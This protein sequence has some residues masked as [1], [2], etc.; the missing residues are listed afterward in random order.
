MAISHTPIYL[1]T[2][3]LE[4][5]RNNGKGPTLLVSDWM[6]YIAE[7]GYIG[8][9][10]W[11]NHLQLASRSEWDLI[12]EK[13]LELDIRISSL[14]FTLPTDNSQKSK[15]IK[16][17]LFEAYDHFE[18]DVLKFSR[19]SSAASAAT[20][21][22]LISAL[23]LMNNWAKDISKNAMVIYDI[24]PAQQPRNAASYNALKSLLVPHKMKFVCRPFLL[25]A[26]E[27]KELCLNGL[28]TVGQMGVQ[29]EIK[30]QWAGLNE[31]K[32]ISLQTINQIK[33]QGYNDSWC[34]EFT[35]GA[36]IAKENIDDLFDNAEN[37]LNFLSGALMSRKT[38][39]K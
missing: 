36:G 21:T 30:N 13:A 14:H 35:R 3:L 8:V 15:K 37:D 39:T 32:P 34:L 19:S 5:N 26:T 22:D 23:Q 16:E 12:R 24:D 9:E 10:I 18:P 6:N 28:E 17:V 38:G 4:K 11:F 7:A 27:L 29:S 2:L 33:E 25:S 1:S 31:N 20:E